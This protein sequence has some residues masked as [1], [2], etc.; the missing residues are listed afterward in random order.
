MPADVGALAVAVGRALPFDVVVTG[1][2]RLPDAAAP[3]L[4]RGPVKFVLDDARLPP[5]DELVRRLPRSP[6]G[7]AGRSPS[8][9]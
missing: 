2:P 8:T 4:P 5:I 6:A 7:P 9:A 1:G 3:G